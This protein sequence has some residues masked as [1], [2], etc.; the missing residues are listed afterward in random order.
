MAY[1]KE[2]CI[3]CRYNGGTPFILRTFKTFEAARIKLM[4][5]IDLEEERHRPYFVENNFFVNKYVGNI[6][7]KHFAIKEREVSDWVLYDVNKN[8]KNNNIIYIDECFNKYKT[9]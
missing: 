4:E 9:N 2:Y 1:D 7:G 5:M 8:I 3:Y 6:P